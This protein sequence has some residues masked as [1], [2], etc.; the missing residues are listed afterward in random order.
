[1]R[2]RGNRQILR[3]EPCDNAN[4]EIKTA[5]WLFELCDMA[6]QN[7][8]GVCCRTGVPKSLVPEPPIGSFWNPY[9]THTDVLIRNVSAAMSKDGKIIGCARA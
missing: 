2:K 1:M 9:I 3:Y 8:L 5:N 4:F 7:W 6:M